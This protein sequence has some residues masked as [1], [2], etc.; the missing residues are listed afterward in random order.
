MDD[1]TE[2][3]QEQ[4]KTEESSTARKKNKRKDKKRGEIQRENNSN[5]NNRTEAFHSFFKSIVPIVKEMWTDRCIGRNTPILGGRIVA[6]YDSLS[7][8][9]TQLYTMREM[10]LPEDE[11]KIFVK[12]LET[13]LENTN[14]QL[15]K[16][17]H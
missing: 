9:I 2:S 5:K 3:I 1:T 10:V 17:I 13:R 14:Q 12:E 16:W 4:E 7:K 11:I 8:K 6:E 15:K